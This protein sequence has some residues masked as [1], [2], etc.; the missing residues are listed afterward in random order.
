MLA[1]LGPLFGPTKKRITT[2]KL[3]ERDSI[4]LVNTLHELFL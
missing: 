4:L 1:D 3:E 2:V